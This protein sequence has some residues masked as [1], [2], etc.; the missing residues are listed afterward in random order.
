MKYLP[1]LFILL[2]ILGRALA[3]DSP[4]MIP[5]VVAAGPI[6]RGAILTADNLYGEGALFELV[7]WPAEFLPDLALSSLAGLE[8][9]VI[10][11]DMTARMPLL[12]SNLVADNLSLAAIGSDTALLTPAGGWSVPIAVDLLA[13]APPTLDEGDEVCVYVL[14]DWGRQ[15]GPAEWL[16]AEGARVTEN[17]YDLGAEVVAVAVEPEAALTLAWAQENGLGVILRYPVGGC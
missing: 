5:V 8:G 16:L 13:E 11:A 6:P 9:Q 3:Q 2:L 1:L 10:R 17:A 15:A 7:L 4:P 12:S 14:L